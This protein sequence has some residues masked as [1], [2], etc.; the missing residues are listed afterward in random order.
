MFI[1]ETT[2]PKRRVTI[3]DIVRRAQT[4]II[5]S[6]LV[7]ALATAIPLA[8]NAAQ[9]PTRGTAMSEF[10]NATSDPI[11]VMQ[12]DIQAALGW[13]NN[14]A[15]PG[16]ASV[17]FK[18]NSLVPAISVVYTL[19]GNQDRI[20]AQRTNIGTFA[21]GQT[22]RDTFIDNE[23]DINQRLEIEQATFADGTIWINPGASMPI[24]RRQA[25]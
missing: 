2:P 25:R 6:L 4:S 22:V 11:Q 20:I 21:P 8:A 19:R 18:N 10:T 16:L 7:A 5:R 17:S 14:F 3:N 12:V 9:A 1:D 23:I 15:Y 24:S 13:A